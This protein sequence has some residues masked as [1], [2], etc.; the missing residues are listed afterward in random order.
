MA[1]FIVRDG[2]LP[3]PLVQC[4]FMHMLSGCG[5]KSNLLL[6]LRY[7]SFLTT[8]YALPSPVQHRQNNA[9]LPTIPRSCD[10][11]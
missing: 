4:R 11:I 10:L 8:F 3:C 7:G 6:L 9:L 5:R 1:S 2:S